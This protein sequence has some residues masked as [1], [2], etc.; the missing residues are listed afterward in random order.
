MCGMLKAGTVCW[1]N[2]YWQE[3]LRSA[4]ADEWSVIWCLLTDVCQFL[5]TDE[6][7]SNTGVLFI[8]LTSQELRV[9]LISRPRLLLHCHTFHGP[10]VSLSVCL[11]GVPCK[12]GWTDWWACGFKEPCVRWRCT[13]AP[14]GEYSRTICVVAVMQTVT[15]IT[16]ATCFCFLTRQQQYN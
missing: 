9:V 11:T 6:C 10:C 8:L 5:S 7:Q 4:E 2:R 16:V 3:L 1:S 15:T 13:L 12:S 14:N